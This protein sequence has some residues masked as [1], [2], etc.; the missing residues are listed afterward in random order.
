VVITY[1]RRADAANEVVCRGLILERQREGIAAAKQR[2]GVYTGRKPALT[3]EQA[4]QLR[5]RP[6][7]ARARP[8]W[9]ESLDMIVTLRRTLITARF[10]TGAHRQPTTEEIPAVH[11]AWT[12]A[13]A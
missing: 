4:Q 1:V 9:P 6:P 11:L 7:P 12:E 2:G 10:R 13:A 3:T 8:C 5:E